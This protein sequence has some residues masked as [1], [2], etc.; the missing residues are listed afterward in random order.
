M[1][2]DSPWSIVKLR[3]YLPAP[4]TTYKILIS[5]RVGGMEGD[6]SLNEG[7]HDFGRH[8]DFSLYLQSLI[9]GISAM[10]GWPWL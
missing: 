6:I 10:R 4:T 3:G 7:A 8:G 5:I 2:R 9:T 1:F